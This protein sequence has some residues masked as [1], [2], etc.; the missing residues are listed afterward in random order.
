[1]RKLKILYGLEAVGGGALKHL[2]YLATNL[3]H[4]IF[5]I[6]IILSEP[7][8][9]SID[10]QIDSLKKSGANLIMLNMCRN[11]NL[12][13]DLW[14]LLKLIALIFKGKYDIVHAH[15][16]KAGGLFRFAAYLCNIP[17]IYYTP[18]CFYFQGKSG[19]KK[20]K[21]VWLEKILAKLTTMLIVSESERK[22][23]IENKITNNSKILNINNAIDFD[24]Y[25]QYNETKTTK[26]FPGCFG[27]RKSVV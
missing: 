18:H 1:M 14:V 20:I 6:T 25:Q 11:I 15:S 7:R 16:S 21:F 27:D 8:N 26:A 19:L 3:D 23:A 5:E 12:F 2:V 9:E 17:A 4:T 10:S 13:K 22:A 24:E